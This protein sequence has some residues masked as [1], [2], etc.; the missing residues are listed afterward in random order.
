MNGE[1]ILQLIREFQRD[2]PRKPQHSVGMLKVTKRRSNVHF[3][4]ATSGHA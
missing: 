2:L 4:F 3:S 1:I